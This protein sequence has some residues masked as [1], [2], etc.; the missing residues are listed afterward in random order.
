MKT[1]LLYLIFGI[2]SVSFLAKLNKDGK[3]QKVTT[4]T[5]ADM[6]VAEHLDLIEGKTIGIITNHTALL[7]NGVH[8]VDTLFHTKGVKIKALFGPEHGVRGKA[9][10]GKHVGNAVDSATG[11][12]VFSLYGKIRK[13]TKE[14]LKGIDLL[15]FDIQD[16]GARYYTYI[17]TLYYSLEGAAENNIPIIVLDRPNPIGGINV[18][19]P[20]GKKGYRSFVGIAPIPI[21]HGMTM[22]ELAKF[23]NSEM[24]PNNLH[25]K[26]TVV[27][28]QNW[29]H[30]EYYDE[31]GL[32]W[33]SPSPNMTNLETA[34]VY[35]GMCLI[36]GTNVSEGRGTIAPF[37]KIGAPFIDSDKLIQ[38]LMKEPIKGVKLLPV[39]FVPVDIPHRAV[40]PKYKG[41]KCNGILIHVTNRKT[42][43]SLRFGIFLLYE[44]H[45][46]YPKQ[47]K[48]KKWIDKLYGSKGLREAIENG[49]TPEEIF[50]TWNNDLIKFKKTRKKF[51]I[52]N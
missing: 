22:G 17:S 40:N 46:L 4:K 32:R 31:T 8:L 15:V 28:L 3:T 11:I 49:K 34:I 50:A 37:L 47:F 51:L 16:I 48:L 30:Q 33:I 21:I 41:E 5:G 20:L 25:A 44:L 52:Y 39:S 7:S 27:K 45:K 43:Q 14:M 10:A 42:F 12:P 9:P 29:K 36:E 23:F 18:D 26:L 35:P 6:L 24:L 38:A 13:P 19:G 1:F 2:L